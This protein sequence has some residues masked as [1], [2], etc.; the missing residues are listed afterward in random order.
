MKRLQTYGGLFHSP[1]VTFAGS[2]KG[3]KHSSLAEKSVLVCMHAYIG[4]ACFFTD[5]FGMPTI[6][7]RRL[8]SRIMWDASPPPTRVRLS[9]TPVL[10]RSMHEACGTGQHIYIHASYPLFD[11]HAIDSLTA[12]LSG[13]SFVCFFFLF[14]CESGGHVRHEGAGDLRDPDREAAAAPLGNAGR[15]DDP[16]DRRR[17]HD[18]QLPV[19]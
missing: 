7:P 16:Q 18:G 9:A 8:S 17:H 14:F 15:Q 4:L 5:E 12:N 3:I 19:I 10:P 1:R 2:Q 6:S 13:G 11:L